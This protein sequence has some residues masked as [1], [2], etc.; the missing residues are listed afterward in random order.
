MS[1]SFLD[2]PYSDR[3]LITVEPDE[4]VKAAQAAMKKSDSPKAII[5]WD[6]VLETLIESGYFRR[7]GNSMSEKLDFKNYI[8]KIKES[9]GARDRG[10]TVIL[11]VS[12]SEA[13]LLQFFPGHPRDRV[14]YVG[15]PAIP[16]V[17]YTPANFHRLCFEHKFCEALHLLMALGAM[18][19]SVER[20]S[21]WNQEFA[22][23]LSVPLEV[24]QVEVSGGTHSKKASHLLYKARLAN[25]TEPKIPEGLVWYQHEPTWQEIAQGRLK[26]GLK[27]FSLSVKYEEDYGINA[28]LKTTFKNSGFV[29]GGKFEDQTSTVWRI[30]GTFHD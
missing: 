29:M 7:W 5:D 21:G 22:A 30:D 4:V 10:K 23:N 16:S 6:L 20:I 1:T 12:R 8:Q 9:Y 15:H 24:V 3:Q 25:T 26:Y 28:E 27:N 11:M 19:I 14:V 17:Y 18:E 13:K 2:M